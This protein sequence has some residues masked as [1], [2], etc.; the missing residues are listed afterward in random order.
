MACMRERSERPKT[1]V[2]APDPK[3]SAAQQARALSASHVYSVPRAATTP[4][5]GRCSKHGGCPTTQSCMQACQPRRECMHTS[6]TLALFSAHHTRFTHRVLTATGARN[7]S[8]V[9]HQVNVD[10]ANA[11]SSATRYPHAL[12]RLADTRERQVETIKTLRAAHAWCTGSVLDDPASAARL[13]AQHRQRPWRS[14]N[15]TA[16]NLRQR[17]S[18]SESRVPQS[19]A[20]LCAPER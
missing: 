2:P 18:K 17:V 15:E 13:T 6:R 12:Q 5:S 14:G 3:M 8:A 1:P 19:G 10:P 16:M 7:H 11:P 9:L 20:V 4:I